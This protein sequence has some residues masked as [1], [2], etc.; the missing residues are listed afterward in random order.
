MSPEQAVG[1]I[2]DRRSDIFSFGA[3]VYE[4]IVGQRAFPG[5]T[6]PDV[7]EA[8]VKNDPDWSKLP[9]GKIEKQAIKVREKWRESKRVPAR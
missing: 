7:L 4:L 1:R 3:V 8:V 5:A 2:V 9:A 6:T